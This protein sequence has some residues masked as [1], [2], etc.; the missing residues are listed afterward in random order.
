MRTN[1]DTIASTL[2]DEKYDSSSDLGLHDPRTYKERLEDTLQADLLNDLVQ[3]K[4]EA[5]SVMADEDRL[6]FD[7]DFDAAY[8]YGHDKEWLLRE[9]CFFL[10]R[11]PDVRGLEFVDFQEELLNKT[12]FE[13][14]LN[15]LEKLLKPTIS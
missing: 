4:A 11:Y 2:E 12:G 3:N 10:R 5:M 15:E 6:E 8:F 1:R 9:V 13:L 7:F 14:D